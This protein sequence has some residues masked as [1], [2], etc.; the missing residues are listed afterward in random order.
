MNARRSS[1]W[2]P[3]LYTGSSH[4]GCAPFAPVSP[5]FSIQHT[6]SSSF[7]NDRATQQ[8]IRN[9]STSTSR[10]INART[11]TYTKGHFGDCMR[12]RATCC[13]TAIH[14][15]NLIEEDGEK[16]ATCTYF[17]RSVSTIWQ[18]SFRKRWGNM[19][20]ADKVASCAVSRVDAVYGFPQNYARNGDDARL[21][22]RTSTFLLI[23]LS[24]HRLASTPKP[25]MPS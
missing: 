5:L 12:C 25:T 4:L 24:S 3:T 8:H 21:M 19:D 9:Y 14:P 20:Q 2:L 23:F 11:V 22:C 13:R 16:I 10:P 18:T 6:D 1:T 17:I 7:R 15:R